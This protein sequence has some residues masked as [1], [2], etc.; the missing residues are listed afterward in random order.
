MVSGIQERRHC[1]I[2]WFLSRLVGE[3]E[4]EVEVNPVLFKSSKKVQYRVTRVVRVSS[5][6]FDPRQLFWSPCNKNAQ[7]RTS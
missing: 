3:G 1:K 5:I 7:F 4:G 6:Y 2:S